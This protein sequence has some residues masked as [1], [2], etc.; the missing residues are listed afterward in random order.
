MVDA[1]LPVTRNIFMWRYQNHKRCQ[2]C[3]KSFCT[4]KYDV[5]MRILYVYLEPLTFPHWVIRKLILKWFW[6]P[7]TTSQ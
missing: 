5:I 1:A 7:V 3:N 4:V 2:T 6:K